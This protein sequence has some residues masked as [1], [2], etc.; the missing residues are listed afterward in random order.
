MKWLF[1]L[2]IASI[3]VGSNSLFARGGYGSNYGNG[4]MTKQRLQDGSGAGKQNKYQYKGS[5]ESQ[6]GNGQKTQQRLKD[7]SGA[8]GQY[9]YGTSSIVE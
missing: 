4:T 2:I 6:Q 9:K 7:G 8:S 3:V 1:F 5:K